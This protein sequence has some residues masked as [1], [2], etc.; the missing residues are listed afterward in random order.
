MTKRSVAGRLGL[1]LCA[2]IALACADPTEQA[3][4]RVESYF[5][6]REGPTDPSWGSLFGH[7]H[8][9][10]GVEIA[11]ASGRPLHEAPSRGIYLRL[12]DPSARAKA[13]EIA[14]LSTPVDRMTALALHCAT[15]GLPAEWPVVLDEASAVGG[16]AL[17]HAA[18]ATEWSLE[19]ECAS[20]PELAAV[21]T[22]QIDALVALADD[23]DGL[24]RG[25][26]KPV[27]LGVEA[28]A[29]LY[30]L[31]ARTR[32]R[33][34]WLEGI[35]AMQRADGGFPGHPGDDHSDPHT[36]ALALW[37]LLERARP[38]VPH[39]RWIVQREAP[40]RT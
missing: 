31:G 34:S 39:S 37:V 35:L 8:R 33:E 1:A 16:Y 22:R 36:S 27:D 20:W 32:V 40:P 7:L 17:T 13:E 29:M 25:Y 5:A 12:D 19:N 30:Y 6:E 21:R 23:W 18:L 3:I 2:C 24:V 4:A 14:R 11:D 38:D 9:R 28:I 10:F 15:V 26:E